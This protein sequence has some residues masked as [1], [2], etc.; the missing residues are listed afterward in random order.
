MSVVID[1]Q[2]FDIPVISL[3]RKADFLDKMAERTSD[4]KLHRE[5]IGVY[6]NYQLVLGT[7]TDMS[8]YSSLWDKLTEPVEFHTVTVP[9]TGSGDYSFTAYFANVT[10]E[11][12]KIK[13]STNYW[14]SLTVNFIA[15]SP[16]KTP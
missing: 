8:E 7:I 15:E 14:K 1:G 2:T 10:D 13:K 5:L 9:D 16:A 3:K 4:G 11:M 6:F 12:R